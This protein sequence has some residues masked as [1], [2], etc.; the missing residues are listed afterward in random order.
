MVRVT[1]D[2]L[3]D[4]LKKVNDA[5]KEVLLDAIR[6]GLKVNGVE[7]VTSEYKSGHVANRFEYS[8][9]DVKGVS[10]VGKKREAKDETAEVTAQ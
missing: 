4:N 1:V 6:N 9:M 8:G 2:L 10:M 3:F 7:T 5:D